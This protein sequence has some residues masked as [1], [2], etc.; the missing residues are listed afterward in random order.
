MKFIKLKDGSHIRADVITGVR[1]GEP[2]AAYLYY[3][4]IKPRV[5]VDIMLGDRGPCVG[6]DCESV[7]ERDACVREIMAQI[8]EALEA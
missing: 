5:V 2:M 6:F 7:E 4:A 8:N 3:P 1:V